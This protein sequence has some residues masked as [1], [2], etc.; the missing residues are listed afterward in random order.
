M[1]ITG[2][3]AAGVRLESP[4]KTVDIRPATDQMREAVFS[5]LGPLVHGASVLDLFAGT[6]SYGLEALSR[7]ASSAIWVEE[8]RKVIAILKR[9]IE[10]TLKS[11][12][13]DS[14]QPS[15]EIISRDFRKV[16]FGTDAAFDL[17]FADPPY[18]KAADWIEGILEKAAPLLRNKPESRLILEFPGDQTFSS[19]GWIEIRRFGKTRAGPSVRVLGLNQMVLS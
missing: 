14:S 11:M 6:G 5:S 4:A 15:T 13:A 16:T 12:G 10:D 2:G 8:N 1:R 18:R 3:Q 19:P 9:N 17:I 7:G